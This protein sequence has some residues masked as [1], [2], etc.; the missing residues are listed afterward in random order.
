M[1]L[2]IDIGFEDEAED[3]VE[4][5]ARAFLLSKDDTGGGHWRIEYRVSGEEDVIYA[6]GTRYMPNGITP[7]AIEA[8]DWRRKVGERTATNRDFLIE[9]LRMVVLDDDNRPLYP[10]TDD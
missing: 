3:I 6:H 2:N 5:E 4:L 8:L 10:T 9:A 7:G 1:L